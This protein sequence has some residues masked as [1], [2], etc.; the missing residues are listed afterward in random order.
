MD[1]RELSINSIKITRKITGAGLKEAKEFV[2]A[3]CQPD[4]DEK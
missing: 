3:W 4:D 1:R 2:E